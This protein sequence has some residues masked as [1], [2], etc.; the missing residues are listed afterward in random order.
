MAALTQVILGGT[1]TTAPPKP[2]DDRANERPFAT[3][4]DRNIIEQVLFATTIFD[5]AIDTVIIDKT[6]VER[7]AYDILNLMVRVL[8]EISKDPALAPRR[9][10]PLKPFYCPKPED[11]VDQGIEGDGAISVALRVLKILYASEASRNQTL[12]KNLLTAIMTR[13]D[14]ERTRTLTYPQC[15]QMLSNAFVRPL[16]KLNELN[17]KMEAFASGITADMMKCAE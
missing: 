16:S 10:P 2:K 15:V 4:V 5:S 12:I 8:V 1:P 6:A 3:I 11:K 14:L 7:R 13:P 9:P 17:A